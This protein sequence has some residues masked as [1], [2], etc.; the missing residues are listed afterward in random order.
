M[1]D[2]DERKLGYSCNPNTSA[3]YCPFFLLKKEKIGANFLDGCQP[4][5][6][7]CLSIMIWTGLHARIV[8][9]LAEMRTLKSNKGN[10]QGE[11]KMLGVGVP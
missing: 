11:E 2:P 10:A 1:R 4:S 9:L 7:N 5:P 8:A 6:G 3:T